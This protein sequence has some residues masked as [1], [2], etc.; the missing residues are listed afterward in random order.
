MLIQIDIVEE[1]IFEEEGQKRQNGQNGQDGQ[2][3]QNQGK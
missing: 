3:G 1:G 2:D